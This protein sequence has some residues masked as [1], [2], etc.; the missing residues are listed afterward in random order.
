MSSGVSGCAAFGPRLP[1]QA[2]PAFTFF[3]C[4]VY[5]H[6]VRPPRQWPVM[7]S[8]DALP[9]ACLPA[10]ATVASISANACSSGRAFALASTSLISE[11]FHN[12]PMRK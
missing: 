10:H 12:S 6:T 11:I 2:T 4:A 5:I 8:F 1:Y 9:R 7:P 3:E